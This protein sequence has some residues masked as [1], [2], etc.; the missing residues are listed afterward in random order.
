[1]GRTHDPWQRGG[2]G[3]PWYATI[4]GKQVRLADGT[5]SKGEARRILIR[6]LAVDSPRARERI[7]V[8]AVLDRWLADCQAR[9]E[10]GEFAPNTLRGYAGWMLSAD[11]AIGSVQ[12]LDLIPLQAQGWLDGTRWGPATRSAAGRALRTAL[13]W[14]HRGGLID[15]DPL[16]A[17][18]PPPQRRRKVELPADLVPRL[19]AACQT[20]EAR[21]L[22]LALAETGCRPSE[23]AAV[24]AAD[25]RDGT[26][27]LAQHKTA[28][29]TG[30]DRVIYLSPAVAE[31]THRLT[32]LHPSG[33]IFRHPSGKPWSRNYWTWQFRQL[34]RVSGVRASAVTLRHHFIT[35]GLARGLSVAVVAELAGHTTARQIEATYGH[36]DQ[37]VELLRAAIQTATCPASVP[38]PPAPDNGAGRRRRRSAP[39]A[40]AARTG[41][42]GRR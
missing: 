20:Q 4:R 29:Q 11:R 18:R 1:V 23:L 39:P 16:A 9:L 37:R 33:A 19:L 32:S 15:R 31:L 41:R 17:W 40:P 30:R 38:T 27:R 5:A 26:W 2:T 14:A 25:V 21:D 10:R 7:T 8:G 36:L 42:R 6:L 34:R 12:V 35:Q 28:R 3:G 24:T 13:R 22:V